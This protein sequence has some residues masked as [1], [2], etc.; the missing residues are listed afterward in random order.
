MTPR[1]PKSFVSPV[2]GTFP[3][4]LLRRLSSGVCP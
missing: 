3:A 4:S 2:F 1:G